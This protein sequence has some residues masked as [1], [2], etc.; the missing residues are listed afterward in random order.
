VATDVGDTGELAEPHAVTL[1]E[2]AARLNAVR[3]FVMASCSQSSGLSLILE[4]AAPGTA[5]AFEMLCYG[6]H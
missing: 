6:C 3:I 4:A 2:R 1:N 5:A